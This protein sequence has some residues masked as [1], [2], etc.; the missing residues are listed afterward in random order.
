MYFAGFLTQIPI[1]RLQKVKRLSA[2]ISSLAS[3]L[4]VSLFEFRRNDPL[5]MA[6]ATS[7]FTTFALTPILIIIIQLLSFFVTRE[8][9]SFQLIERLRTMIG[10]RS[11]Q[12]IQQTLQNINQLASNW[13]VTLFG[14]LFLLFVATTLFLVIEDSLNQIWKIRIKHEVSFMFKMKRRF[15]SLVIIGLAGLLF[16]VGLVAEGI[17]TFLG[18]YIEVIF[19]RWA[20]LFDSILNETIFVLIVTIWFT[21]LFRY[22][23]EGRPVWRIALAG[24]LLTSVLFTVGKMIVNWGLSQSNIGTIYGAS[25]SVILIQLFVFYSSLIF[26]FGGSFIKTLSEKWQEEIRPVEGAY[27]YEIHE[28][29]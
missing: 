16:I 4:K 11:A 12:Q 2:E 26:Y 6:G 13:Y 15:R 14:F 10:N 29:F 5:R 28:V 20:W 17:Q 25:G 7:F 22:L 8:K 27:R 23:T 1:V 18:T 21:V 24:G 3:L 9:L 19:T